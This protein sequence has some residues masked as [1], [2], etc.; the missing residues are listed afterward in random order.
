MV[1]SEQLACK[2]VLGGI[3]FLFE[4]SSTAI[5]KDAFAIHTSMVWVWWRMDSAKLS[6]RLAP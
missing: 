4:P 6:S 2:A 1:E 3:A 5:T